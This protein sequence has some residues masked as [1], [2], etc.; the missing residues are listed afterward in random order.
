MRVTLLI[1]KEEI[2]IKSIKK[3]FKT[4]LINIRKVKIK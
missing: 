4:N 1:L 3:A 2:N